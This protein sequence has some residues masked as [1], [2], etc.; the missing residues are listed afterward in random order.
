MRFFY[1]ILLLAIMAVVALAATTE[2]KP[3]IVSFPKGTPGHI[4]E[5]AMEAVRKAVGSFWDP[6]HLEPG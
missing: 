2:Q 4:V 3:V 1:N 6:V 5:E